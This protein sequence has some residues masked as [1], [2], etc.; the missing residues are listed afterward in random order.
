M[1]LNQDAVRDI[2]LFV[3]SDL[4]FDNFFSLKD[5]YEAEVLKKYGQ[6][7]IKYTLLKLSETNYLHSNPLISNNNLR[8]FSTGMLTWEGHEFL[9]TIRDAQVWSKTK[10]VTNKLESVSIGM[11]S[12]IGTGVINHMID[13]TMGF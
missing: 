1:R 6:D 9:D 2:M 4:E 7:T 10:I 13:K 8:D 5:F 12:R 11:L 3:E